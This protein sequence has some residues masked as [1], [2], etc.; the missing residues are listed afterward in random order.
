MLQLARSAY[1]VYKDHLEKKKA[2]IEMKRKASEQQREKMLAEETKKREAEEV[3]RK[4]KETR[5]SVFSY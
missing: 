4:R 5:K 1:L 3:E 2:E